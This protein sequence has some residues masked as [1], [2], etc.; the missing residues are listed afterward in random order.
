MLGIFEIAGDRR[1][2]RGAQHARAAGESFGS[3]GDRRHCEP[4]KLASLEADV[5]SGVD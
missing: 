4:R 5:I 1:P 2:E 3:E